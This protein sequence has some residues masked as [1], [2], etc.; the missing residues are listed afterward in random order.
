[1]SRLPEASFSH[2]ARE[3]GQ[4]GPLSGGVR[5]VVTLAVATAA[6]ATL[7]LFQPAQARDID[8]SVGVQLPG[9][10]LQARTS[11]PVVVYAPPSY[12]V[13]VHQAPSHPVL[14]HQAPVYVSPVYQAMPP[15]RVV[16]GDP[17]YPGDRH[18]RY[19]R[20]HHRDDRHG[21][22]HGH[23]HQNWRR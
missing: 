11:P 12:P 1:M 7:A 2:A 17:W 6:W 18:H 20:K 9:T 21:H 22:G 8:W 14:V 23:G 16:Y 10:V 19:Y 5:W 15:P 4:V 13:V 3:P